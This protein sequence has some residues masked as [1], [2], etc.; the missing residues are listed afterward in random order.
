MAEK[1]KA[2]V[3]DETAL[4]ELEALGEELE[5][6]DAETT[7]DADSDEEEAEVTTPVALAKALDINPKAL[8]GWL[9]E[10]FT[11]PLA[12]K[13]TSWRLNQDMVDAA[14]ARFAGETED[15]D[16]DDE[17]VEV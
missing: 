16:A 14:Y 9:R 7:D 1:T 11:R 12:E 2:E 17:T 13:N 6:S 8:R 4:E 5:E 15:E 10:N 3:L